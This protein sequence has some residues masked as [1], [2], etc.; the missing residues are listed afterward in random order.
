MAYKEM[1]TVSIS[2]ETTPLQR[3]SFGIPIFIGAHNYFKDRVRSYTS[4]EGISEDLPVTSDEYKA[5]N[6][7]FAQIPA[8]DQIKIGRAQNDTFTFTPDPVTSIGQVYLIEVEGTDGVTVNTSFTT[9]TGSETATDIVTALSAGLA[10]LAGVTVSGTTT[11]ILSETAP[12]DSF[13]VKDVVRLVGAGS[14][15]EAPA[16][17]LT[18]I[19]EV[20]DE[21]YFVTANNHSNTYIQAMAAAIE[22]RTKLYYYTTPDTDVLSGA[23][24]PADDPMSY[25]QD[26]GYFRTVGFYHDQ[27][28]TY[29]PEMG[30]IVCWSTADAGKSVNANTIVRGVPSP[31]NVG[32][33]KLTTSE[34]T[35]ILDRNGNFVETTA[36]VNIV[37]AQSGKTAGGEWVDVMRNRDVLEAR[38]TEAYQS[39]LINKPVVTWDQSDIDAL[40][41]VLQTV[42]DGFRSKPKEPN[43]L[44]YENPYVIKFPRSKDISATTKA[45]RSFEG[46]VD[47]YLAGAIQLVKITGKLGYSQ[48]A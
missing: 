26:V 31:K 7:A 32:G 9:T 1:V 14:S 34:K 16:D 38:I 40:S 11:L 44:E 33:N 18:A 6:T 17:T 30:Y 35:A 25:C 27:D 4:M 12:T 2:L 13:A 28:T 23:P 8:P 20:D 21:Y 10:A 15:T 3:A 48:E 47:M 22:S 24:V 5:A 43:V 37:S 41:N 39:F 29:F 46:D 42:L 19:S 36:G 45:T